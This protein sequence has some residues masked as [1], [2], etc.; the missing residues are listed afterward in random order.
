MCMRVQYLG[1]ALL[2]MCGLACVSAGMAS[3]KTTHDFEAE[4]P[5]ETPYILTGTA[6]GGEIVWKWTSGASMACAASGLNGTI[7]ESPLQK[8]ELEPTYENCTL[9]GLPA[10]VD[11]NCKNLFTGETNASGHGIVHVVCPSELPVKVTVNG[12]TI[13]VGPQTAEQGA[14]YTSTGSGSSR[15]VDFN[16]TMTKASNK[17]VGAACSLIAGLAGELSIVGNY[18]VKA[19]ADEGGAEGK[20]IG[21]WTKA[22]IF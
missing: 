18:T 12:C 11:T 20:Q 4:V 9:G 7:K 17:L 6:P 22:T 15:D 13:E 21:F 10:T 8:L 19:Y 2:A 1:V 5:K 3:A 14:H 16:V